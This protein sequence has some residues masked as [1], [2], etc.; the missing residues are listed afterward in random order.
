VLVMDEPFL[1]DADGRDVGHRLNHRE[2]VVAEN[3]PVGLEEVQGA[4]RL[5]PKSHG[6]R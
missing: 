3:A 2:I 1:D 5:A 6:Y 4:D